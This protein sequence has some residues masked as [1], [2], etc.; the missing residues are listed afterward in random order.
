MK[1]IIVTGGAGYIGSH[2][3]LSLIRNKYLPIILDNFSNSYPSIIKKLEI[4]TKKK[5][6]FHQVDLRNKA[7]LKSIICQYSCHA[8]IHCASLKSVSESI[9][10]P[11][12]YFDNNLVSTLSLLEVLDEQKI[13]KMIFSSSAA[14]YDTNQKMPLNENSKIS[15]SMSP[16]GESKL[17][18]EKILQNICNTNLNWKI[19]VARYF[20]PVG[21]DRSGLI[22]D[23]PKKYPDNIFPSVIRSLKAEKPFKIFGK[24]YQT[25]D[26]TCIRDYI[27]VIDLAEGHIAMLKKNKLKKGINIFN[28]GTGKGS[29]V[30]EVVK[31]FKKNSASSFL[32]KFVPRRKGD[33][34][35]SVCD[36]RKAR[37]KLSWKPVYSL[38]D[39]VIDSIT[40]AN[41]R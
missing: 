37:K 22:G 24:N 29:T 14:V 8:V 33:T 23:H 6:N 13:Y 25:R 30:L 16:Y 27:H 32:Y 28:F 15:E 26:G 18:I 2:L 19:G 3:V 21:N 1:K 5:I 35:I 12:Q 36:F 41:N 4:I 20:N 40:Y 7:R 10:M 31:T 38:K 11:I 17:M 39:A 34:Q 9:E